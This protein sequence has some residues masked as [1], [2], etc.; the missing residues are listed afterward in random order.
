MEPEKYRIAYINSCGNGVNV[1]RLKPVESALLT[2]KPGQFVKVF[3]HD[4]TLFRPYSISSEPEDPYIEL[5]I[6]TVSGGAFTS[7]MNTLKLGDTLWLEG[8]VGNFFFEEGYDS[9]FIAGGV[10]VSPIIGMLRHVA[11]KNLKGNYLFLYSNKKKEDIPYY[12]ELEALAKINPNIKLV[13]TLTQ[14]QPSNWLGER[15]RINRDMI[16]KYLPDGKKKRWY[17]CGPVKMVLDLRKA[18]TEL[19]AEKDLI[20]IEAWG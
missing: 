19:G 13:Y 10:G 6:K 20:K 2:F 9:I 7:Y 14:E 8:P 16:S 5:C 3:N 12:E 11:R 18:I 15:G 4:K 1:F 17:M